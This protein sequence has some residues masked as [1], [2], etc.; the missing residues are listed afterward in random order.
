MGLFNK[1][2]CFTDIHFGLKNN[3][4]QHNEDC[5]NFVDWAI[6]VAKNKVAKLE[7]S[8]A[9]G[10]TIVAQLIYTLWTTV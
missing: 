6:S 8:W 2:L 9:I 3:S 4:V 1:A 5:L 7:C 10:I